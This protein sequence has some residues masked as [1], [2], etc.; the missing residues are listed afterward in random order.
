MGR[1]TCDVTWEPAE[2]VPVKVIEEFEKGA[3][4]G[5][6]ESVAL[7]GVGQH[8]HTLTVDENS[9]HSSSSSSQQSR[10]VV[11]DNGG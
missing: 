3:V 4:H 2:N 5:V 1:E 9:T 7:S 6:K 8:V 11:K 10:T